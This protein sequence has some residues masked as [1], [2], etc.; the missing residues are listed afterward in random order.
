MSDALLSPERGTFGRGT[1]AP[2]AMARFSS[3]GSPAAGVGPGAGTETCGS[4]SNDLC[5]AHHATS[6]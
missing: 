4:M 3:Y 1:G 6:R 2:G 5:V